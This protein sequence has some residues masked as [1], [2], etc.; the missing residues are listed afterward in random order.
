MRHFDRLARLVSAYEMLTNTKVRVS[1]NSDVI[2]LDGET[3]DCQT[4]ET[5][6]DMAI[7]LYDEIANHAA[8]EAGF[9]R[10]IMKGTN[11]EELD[12]TGLG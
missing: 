7:W 2:C 3:R 5:E 6:E 9:L 4:F 11:D 10:K 8:A 1:Q 12:T